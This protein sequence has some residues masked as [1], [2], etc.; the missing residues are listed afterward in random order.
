MAAAG[1]GEAREP[2]LYPPFS[3][4]RAGGDS[5]GPEVLAE[6]PSVRV[7]FPARPL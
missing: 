5:I 2:S 1:T 7:I 4:D 6:M 3:L